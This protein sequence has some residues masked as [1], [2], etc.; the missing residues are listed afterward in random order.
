MA[1]KKL[2]NALAFDR[3]VGDLLELP[4]VQRLRAYR[5]HRTDRYEHSLRVARWSFRTARLLG[6]DERAAARG[7]VLH[8]LFYHDRTCRP[9]GYEGSA[10][11]RHPEEAVRNAR[12][13]TQLTEKEEDI[14]RSHMWPVSPRHIPHSAEAVLVNLVDDVV[15]VRDLMGKNRKG[16]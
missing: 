7:A 9:E 13:L 1:M 4:E 10:F 16:L 14:I 8:D 2:L 12:S 3:A 6:L 11:V 15:S 5:H